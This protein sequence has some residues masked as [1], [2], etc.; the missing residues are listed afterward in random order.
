MEVFKSL[1][2]VVGADYGSECSSPNLRFFVW[3]KLSVAE[4]GRMSVTLE[5]S[6]FPLNEKW[7]KIPSATE[8]KG[9]FPKDMHLDILIG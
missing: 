3:L 7:R 2:Q 6:Y 1:G 5:I 4:S 9:F 8:V